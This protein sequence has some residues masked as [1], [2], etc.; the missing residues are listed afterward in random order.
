[1]RIRKLSPRFRE[2]ERHLALS[3]EEVIGNKGTVWGLPSL[4]HLFS[5]FKNET[6]PN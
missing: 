6:A 2:G 1:M 4:N 3:L 5:T